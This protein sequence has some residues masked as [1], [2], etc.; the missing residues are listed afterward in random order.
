MIQNPNFNF[1]NQ[2]FQH[3][4]LKVISKKII[5]KK[6]DNNNAFGGQH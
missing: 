6:K 1:E 5:I 2:E 4:Q 3:F